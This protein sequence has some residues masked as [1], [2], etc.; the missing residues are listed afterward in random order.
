[1]HVVAGLFN[2]TGRDEPKKIHSL[3]SPSSIAGAALSTFFLL[4]VYHQGF[5][6]SAVQL[7]TAVPGNDALSEGDDWSH[8]RRLISDADY[9]V[10]QYFM[11][12]ILVCFSAL[13]SGLTLGLLGLDK[14]GLQIV[15]SGDNAHLAAKAAKIAPIRDNG[16]LLLCTLLLGNVAVNASLSILMADLTSGLFGFVF[17]TI[18]IVIFGEIIPQAACS[19]YALDIGAFFVPV[20]QV[21]IYILF[22]F[23]KPLSLVLDVW[24][25]DEI[26]TIHTRQELSELLRI[27]V[28]HGAMDIEAGNVAQGAIKYQNMLVKDVM[29]EV[30]KCYMLSASDNLNFKKITEIFKSGFSR[31]PVYEKN[32]NDI[33]GLLLVKDLIFVDPEDETPIRNF[34]QIFG[35]SFLLCWPDQ[36]LGDTLRMFKKGGSHMA[37]VRDVKDGEDGGDPYYVIAGVITLEDIL[38]EI[39]GDEIMD[40]TDAAM[41]NEVTN[42]IASSNSTF[43]YD[44]LRLL[45][46]GKLEYEK[47][48]SKEAAAIGSHLMKNVPQLHKNSDGGAAP[49]TE[50]IMNC[51][52]DQCPVYDLVRSGDGYGEIHDSDLLFRKGECCDSMI[53]VLTGKLIVLAGR[54]RFRSEAGPWTILGADALVMPSGGAYT[55][56]FSAYIATETLRC[57]RVSREEFQKARSGEK[58]FGKEGDGSKKTR[59]SFFKGKGRKEEIEMRSPL[60]PR[61][62]PDLL[63]NGD[64]GIMSMPVPPSRISSSDQDPTAHGG[65]VVGIEMSDTNNTVSNQALSS[66]RL[67]ND[68]K[69][70]PVYEQLPTSPDSDVGRG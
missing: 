48:T 19:R 49:L 52:L 1:M 50:E 43:D 44:R 47:I 3:Y 17:S 8:R 4:L 39:I 61:G 9:A 56:D 34:I 7:M 35:R 2:E 24:L 62:N 11:I 33:I 64:G 18:I 12:I 6:D 46:S 10:L 15:M 16:N 41:E 53:L 27:H 29:V 59:G 31:I 5:F 38:E 14:I 68:D 20:V 37:I 55:P 60:P 45:D 36:K 32:K 65:S 69:D 40:E 66:K 42:E 30:C 57:I 54:D 67:A 23:T 51:L 26:G 25:G 21:L 22:V 28:D 58:V 63:P 13:F 70:K